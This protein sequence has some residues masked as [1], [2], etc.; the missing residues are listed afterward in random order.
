MIQKRRVHL[1]SHIK[2]QS[3]FFLEFLCSITSDGTITIRNLKLAFTGRTVQKLMKKN[4]FRNSF[5]QEVCA[6]C[7][8]A[9]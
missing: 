4:T 7:T 8:E 6:T 3:T 9:V 5:G 1:S 2:E